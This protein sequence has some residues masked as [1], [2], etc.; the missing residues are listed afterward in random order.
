MSID[1][2]ISIAP[3]MACTNRH[4]RMLMRQMTRHTLLYTE[5]VTTG[6]V[7]HGD[8]KKLLAYSSEEQP[9][10]LQLGG[11]DPNALAKSAEIA[12]QYGYNEVNLNVGCPSERVQSGRF[13]ACLMKE[14]ELVAQCFS[15]MR[16]AVDIPVTVKTR[17]GVDEHDQYQDL[18][19]FVECVAKAGCEVFIIHARKAWLNGLSPRE[20]REIPP[21]RYDLVYRL[22]QDFPECEIIINGGIKTIEQM[23]THLQHCDGVMIGREAYSNPTLFAEID[24]AFFDAPDDVVGAHEVLRNYMPYVAKQLAQGVPLRPLIHHLIGLFQ[25]MPGAR[26]W[27]RYLSE[28]GGENERGVAVINEALD[29]MRI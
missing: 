26:L 25:G 24:R 11:S 12:Q 4:Y 23:Q 16:H 19:R 7:L 21:L 20:N 8:R 13:G 10:A 1:R 17:I 5:M 9:L 2:T 18:Y 3:M 28:H 29:Q 22:K 14:S 6:A 15:A 27:R